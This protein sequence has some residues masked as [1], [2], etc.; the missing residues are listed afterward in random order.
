MKLAPRQLLV[1]VW[2]R[3]DL[4]DAGYELREDGS[5]SVFEHNARQKTS[6]WT[7]VREAEREVVVSVGQ[8]KESE[9]R[10][11]FETDDSMTA[12]LPGGRASHFVRD[13]SNRTLTISK[14]A[15]CNT[16]ADAV[17]Q[18]QPGPADDVS[19]SALSATAARLDENAKL[20]AAVNTPDPRLS[21]L[22]D[23]YAKNVVGMAAAFRALAVAR[24]SPDTE[25]LATRA[26][27]SSELVAQINRYCED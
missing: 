5:F 4:T 13:T 18:F 9:V 23:A 6:K 12:T 15:Q 24:D 14:R 8:G 10:F 11:T 19:P 20:V 7:L 25:A 21:E 3:T 2:L 1:G 16:L 22:R 26:E 17:N 27:Q